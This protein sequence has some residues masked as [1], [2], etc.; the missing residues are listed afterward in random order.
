LQDWLTQEDN[1]LSSL[2]DREVRELGQPD[3]FW[4]GRLLLHTMEAQAY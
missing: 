4:R 2:T 3:N 1:P